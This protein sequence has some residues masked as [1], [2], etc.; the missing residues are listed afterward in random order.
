MLESITRA[1]GEQIK[2][3]ALRIEQMT[4]IAYVNNAPDMRNAQMNDA[5]VKA[6]DPQLARIALKKIANRKSTTP[7]TTSNCTTGRKLHQEDIT[8]THIDRHKLNPNSTFS[9]L[10]NNLSHEI[11]NLTVDDV[12]TMEQDIAH[13][14]SVVRHKYSNDPNFKGKTL[15]LKLCKKCSRSGHIISTCPE[16]GYKKPLDKPKFQK[17]TFNQAMK[18]NQ[19]LP[20]RQV[21]SNILTG[22]QLPFSHGSRSN[23]RE[24]RNNSRHRM[25]YHKITQNPTM[26][27]AILNHRVETVHHTQEQTFKPTPNIILDHNHLKITKK[28]IAHDDSSHEIDFVMSGITLIHC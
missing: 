9:P 13:G 24:H 26:E 28:E 18:G 2:T 20:N 23:N 5:L 17:Q 8:R 25:N 1:S 21:T 14:I 27:T 22:K 3:L 19:N 10:I 16:K 12:H 4:R 15:F 6:L 7:S 11:D